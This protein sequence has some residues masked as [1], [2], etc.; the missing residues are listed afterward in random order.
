MV[1]MEGHSGLTAGDADAGGAVG[2]GIGF[3]GAAAAV[4]AA[5][6]VGTVGGDARST[7]GAVAAG[8]I[9]GRETGSAGGAAAG[10]GIAD[11]APCPAAR[12]GSPELKTIRRSTSPHAGHCNAWC[13]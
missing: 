2:D 10:A 3:G 1:S 6:A 4:G 5:G 11:G 12:D 13:S 8:G 7:A 9:V